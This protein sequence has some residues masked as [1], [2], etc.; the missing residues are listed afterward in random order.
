MSN[1]LTERD[2][3]ID[4][5]RGLALLTIFVDHIPGNPL[6]RLTFQNFGFSDAADVFVLLAGV[7]SG[8]ARSSVYRWGRTFAR[9]RKVYGAHLALWVSAVCF[10][11]IAVTVGATGV[12]E[13]QALASLQDTP[14]VAIIK[15][16]TLYN[17]PEYFD[18]LP[19]YLVL[20]MWLPV[21]NW[22]ATRHMGIAL[23]C[24]G[25]I[26]L[27]ANKLQ[28]NLPSQRDGGWF[29]NPLAWQ[30]LFCLGIAIGRRQMYADLKS[31]LPRSFSLLLAALAFVVFAGLYAAPWAQFP[32]ES[33]RSF[34]LFVPGTIGDISKTYE[35]LWRVAHVLCCAYVAAWCSPRGRSNWID[36][37]IA[38]SVC[39]LGRNSLTAFCMIS[40]LS[41]LARVEFEIHQLGMSA[42]VVASALCIGL[43]LG[44]GSWTGEDRRPAATRDST[45]EEGTWI[46][47]GPENRDKSPANCCQV[48]LDGRF[49]PVG[50]VNMKT[51][52]RLT[53][54]A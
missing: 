3:R 27:L 34:R 18:I 43:L 45:P 28:L 11:W 17:Q 35:S 46:H 41:L 19:L 47:P 7:S 44:F 37:E 36:S 23:L 5:F 38:K 53:N 20:M 22:L 33:W 39:G 2:Q 15:T 42:C 8:R 31:G 16:A 10:A 52:A 6:A 4:F 21:F 25:L 50:V 9:V 26:W 32:I 51:N 24:S 54:C 12:W 40:I 29:F 13:H 1:R 30:L 48:G 14:W 49:R